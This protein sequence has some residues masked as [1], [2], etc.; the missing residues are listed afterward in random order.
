M[1]WNG[2][3]TYVLPPAYSPE[4]NGAVIDANRYNGLTTDVATGISNALNK[5]GEN[6]PTANINWGGFKLQN[7]ASP[8]VSG[9]AISWGSSPTFGNLS[10][11]LFTL[12][13][14]GSAYG[15]WNG[16][17]AATS[18]WVIKAATA[19]VGYLGTSEG[20]AGL[21]GGIGL[22]S[23]TYT[24]IYTGGG[25]ERIRVL[26]AGQVVLNGTVLA[27]IGSGADQLAV[28]GPLGIMTQLNGKSNTFVDL[29]NFGTGGWRF[30]TNVAG[31]LAGTISAAGAWGFG[32][33]PGSGT[34]LVGGNYAQ[35]TDTVYNGYFGKS[36]AIIA[37]GAVADLGIASYLG[38]MVFGTGGSGTKRLRLSASTADIFGQGVGLTRVKAA[39]TSR[40]SV[41]V[42]A[43]D[44]DLIVPLEVGKYAVKAWIPFN[45]ASSGGMGIKGNLAF[46]GTQTSFTASFIC[47]EVVFSTQA[48]AAT[49]GFAVAAITTSPAPG[50]W[51]LIEGQ[52]VV[53]VAGNISFQWAQNSSTAVNL[54]VNVGA[55]LA[56][57]KVG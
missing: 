55:Y 54:N 37:G 48:I 53:T 16:A 2:L 33:A 34:I 43:D 5:N 23:E 36:N 6:S 26:A 14:T 56:C 28:N 47:N 20:I 40:Q 31:V 46:S 8:T 18:Y 22:R 49:T 1:P 12:S 41:T 39:L 10:S 29:A 17:S 50:S 24:S 4:S 42:V 51:V 52:I 27:G 44:P 35:F 3:G 57:T 25:S 32:A 15:S 30:Y 11:D 13:S 19:I 45:A 21:V 9:D 38:D 7:L